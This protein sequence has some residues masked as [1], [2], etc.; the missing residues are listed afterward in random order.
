MTITVSL[1]EILYNGAWITIADAGGGAYTIDLPEIEAPAGPAPALLVTSNGVAVSAN[2]QVWISATPALSLFASLVPAPGTTL[3]GTVNWQYSFATTCCGSFDWYCYDSV[4]ASASSPWDLGSY[5]GA[6]G[7]A[8][9]VTATYAGYAPQSLT[10]SILGTNPTKAA[11][12]SFIGSSPWFLHQMVQLESGYVQFAG[13]GGPNFGPPNGFGLMQ[14]DPPGNAYQIW[15]WKQ[16]ATAGLAILSAFGTSATSYWN[17]LLAN[18]NSF[19]VNNPDHAIGP[20]S[21]TSEGPCAF[22]YNSPAGGTY[23]YSDAVWIK[24]YNSGYSSPF[25]QLS[26]FNTNGFPQAAWII[27]DLNNK[28]VDY[29][30]VVCSATP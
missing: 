11:V 4:T 28:G 23:P 27:N 3:S 2:S 14:V 7:G 20:P 22:S 15:D 6:C 5:V 13:N 17:G 16:N 24:S 8:A 18:W 10:F 26:I 25:I 9:T 12:N 21:D 1:G 29:V 19:N 30:Q